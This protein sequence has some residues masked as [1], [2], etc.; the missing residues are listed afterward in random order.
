Q[1]CC[2]EVMDRWD[3]HIA[4]FLGDGAVIYFGW[5][6]AHEDDAERAVRASLELLR[7]VRR[8][9]VGDGSMLAARAG[10]A[11]GLVM[12][13]E[14]KSDALTQREG[15]VGAT[16]NLAA[17]VQAVA[18]PGT[19]VITPGTRKLIGDRFD[20]ESLGELEFKGIA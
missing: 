8:L 9:P 12:V 7:S 16:P 6:R 17:R 13:G 11:T 1:D 20:L 10:I 19:V 2:K 18:T 14:T 5:P 3:G 4:E 15:V